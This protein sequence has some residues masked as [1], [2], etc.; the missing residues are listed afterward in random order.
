[1]GKCHQDTSNGS[2]IDDDY[3]SGSAAATGQTLAHFAQA[4][5]YFW[6]RNASLLLNF[7]CCGISFLYIRNTLEMKPT[8]SRQLT[9]Q[10]A[11][12]S[13]IRTL[14][15]R[16]FWYPVVQVISF[17]PT[18]AWELSTQS[19]IS[20]NQRSISA[21]K[22]IFQLL[23]CMTVSFGGTGFF[24]A[25]LLVQPKATAILTEW[26]EF[27]CPWL[28]KVARSVQR[29]CC[30]CH[31][32]WCRAKGHGDGGM[33]SRLLSLAFQNPSWIPYGSKNS[34]LVN[35]RGS[36]PSSKSMSSTSSGMS[37]HAIRISGGAILVG[38]EHTKSLVT[39]VNTRLSYVET[40][41]ENEDEIFNIIQDVDREIIRLSASSALSGS[42]DSRGSGGL[43]SVFRDGDRRSSAQLS[44][45]KRASQGDEKLSTSPGSAYDENL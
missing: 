36:A 37:S 3:T 20:F 43:N 42:R 14:V 27:Y 28:L 22:F 26:I 18:V 31:C 17:A 13:A 16:M 5:L 24:I 21:G 9:L 30:N 10:E 23:L 11:R 8:I 25:F 2:V 39:T 15:V 19:F 38:D 29:L 32:C 6:F 33:D 12:D 1:V 35:N 7:T 41:D 40:P 34:S 4:D 44:S 45:S